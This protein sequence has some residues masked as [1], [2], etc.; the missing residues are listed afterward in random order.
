MSQEIN[1]RSRNVQ[2]G[3]TVVELLV[4]VFVFF[5]VVT[6]AVGSLL[7]I[8]DANRRAQSLNG[9]MN[10]LQFALE[11]MAREI[12]TGTHYYC[13][14]GQAID[15]TRDCTSASVGV[16]SRVLS[17]TDQTGLRTYYT[18]TEGTLVRDTNFYDGV[19]QVAMSGTDVQITDL[20]F[21]VDG[22]SR[23]G[24]QPRVT[25]VVRGK[26]TSQPDEEQASFDVQTVITQRI[27]D[28]N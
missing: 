15:A 27:Y 24:S 5:I 17:F 26:T 7:A 3:F 28:R 10:N 19:G 9:V 1:M 12:R 20:Q 21:Y 2:S 8:V 14:I 23:G 4:S 22:S 25:M 18:L 6:I 11:S 13:G 16:S